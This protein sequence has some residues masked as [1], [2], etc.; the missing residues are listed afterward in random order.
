MIVEIG[1][2]RCVASVVVVDGYGGVL[3][4]AARFLGRQ[5]LVVVW[6]SATAAFEHCERKVV[7]IKA[8]LRR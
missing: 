5:V 3:V 6:T 4:P 7:F 2:N 1:D 8:E